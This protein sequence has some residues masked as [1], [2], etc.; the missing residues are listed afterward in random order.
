MQRVMADEEFTMEK[1]DQA[2]EELYQEARQ[3][4]YV[5]SNYVNLRTPEEFAKGS[6][7]NKRKIMD[8]FLKHQK[9]PIGRS[10][11]NLSND[12]NRNAIIAF[13][14]LLGYCGDKA[15][16]FPASQALDFLQIGVNNPLLR[17]ELYLQAIKQINCNP[18]SYAQARAFHVLCLC[19]DVFPPMPDLY[20][21]VL[22]FLLSHAESVA[23]GADPTPIQ[24]MAAY[25]LVRIQAMHNTDPENINFTVDVEAVEAYSAR[26]PTLAKVYSPDDLLLGE[27]LV[28]PDVDVE[29]LIMLL[30]QILGIHLSRRSILGLYVVTTKSN[31]LA[32]MTLLPDKDFFI[33]DICQ[34]PLLQKYGRPIKFYIR[35][36]LLGPSSMTQFVQLSD[37]DEEETEEQMQALIDLT[38]TQLALRVADDSIKIPDDKTM[39]HLAAIQLATEAEYIPGRVDIALG[40]GCLNFVSESMKEA[41][42]PEYWGKLIADALH[43]CV[44]RDDDELKREYL[45]LLEPLPSAGMHT[46][47][48]IKGSGCSPGKTS[49]IPDEVILGVDESGLHFINGESDDLQVQF[50][51]RYLEIR[52]FSVKASSIR[53]TFDAIDGSGVPYEV[54]LVTPLNEEI[55]QYCI[56]YRQ[57]HHRGEARVSVQ[58][59]TGPTAAAQSRLEKL[60]AL[61]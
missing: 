20:Y 44:N 60:A 22:N 2:K 14:S 33:G 6:M 29:A 37:V 41:Q 21:Y 30:C 1:F 17:N 18:S 4:I 3:P 49:H 47:M 36:K 27:L 51:A 56:I 55:A 35:R 42:T 32:P 26:L 8:N 48:C 53:F 5:F 40:Q 52:K 46:Y 43:K 59:K 45:S 10:L 11:T 23:Q 38:F 39:A 15:V 7:L 19:C 12:D 34:A 13:K 58:G 57:S 61:K 31:A 16:T 50:T 54:E 9:S 24:Q 25:A 28:A